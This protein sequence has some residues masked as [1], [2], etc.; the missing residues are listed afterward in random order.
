MWLSAPRKLV[1]YV[2][3][4]WIVKLAFRYSKSDSRL[5]KQFIIILRSF[6]W[7]QFGYYIFIC[8]WCN[9]VMV[10]NFCNL[11]IVHR[12]YAKNML[13]S[14]CIKLNTINIYSFRQCFRSFNFFFLSYPSKYPD[15]WCYMWLYESSDLK[16]YGLLDY[17]L[18]TWFKLI[19]KKWTRAILQ[20]KNK[21]LLY[22]RIADV[23]RC[24]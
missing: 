7:K 21:T 15:V 14:K 22:N 16:S 10:F 2:L 6:Y 5:L 1:Y 19:I 18:P 12:R 11:A 9:W 23:E 8:G 3:F 24:S 13:Y 17:P 20:Q 4:K